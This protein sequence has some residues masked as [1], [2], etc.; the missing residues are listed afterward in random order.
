MTS[1]IAAIQKADSGEIF[2]EGESFHVENSVEAN[3]KGICMI[4]QEKGTFD[5]LTVAKNIFVGKEKNVLQKW[6]P[7]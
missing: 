1:I 3:E 5:A 6:Y 4:L 7:Q 2:L